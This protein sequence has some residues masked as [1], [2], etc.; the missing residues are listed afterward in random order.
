MAVRDKSFKSVFSSTVNLNTL[1]CFNPIVC[2]ENE[3]G[4]LLLMTLSRQSSTKQ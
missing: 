3:E 4:I 1:H 2:S